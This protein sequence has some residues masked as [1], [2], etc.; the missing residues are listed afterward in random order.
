MGNCQWKFEGG[1]PVARERSGLT[2]NLPS[3]SCIFGT[4]SDLRPGD[5]LA[6]SPTLSRIVSTVMGG[7]TYSIITGKQPPC[8]PLACRLASAAPS[9]EGK[10]RKHNISLTFITARK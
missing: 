3:M 10:E 4:G 5:S 1:T 8:C 6:A 9:V 7:D 2:D